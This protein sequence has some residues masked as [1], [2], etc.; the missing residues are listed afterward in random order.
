MLDT[1]PSSMWIWVHLV[2]G[3][4]VLWYLIKKAKIS[5]FATKFALQ[6]SIFYHFILQG[7]LVPFITD[8]IPNIVEKVNNP[9]LLGSSLFVT[10]GVYFMSLWLIRKGR[11]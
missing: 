5:N 9:V 6:I 7:F 2:L 8:K 3:V 4:S 10:I 1:I 11:R